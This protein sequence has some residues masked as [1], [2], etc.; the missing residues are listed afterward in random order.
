MS[1]CCY[2]VTVAKFDLKKTIESTE[3]SLKK[4]F[5]Q[6]KETITKKIDETTDSSW[7]P[8]KKIKSFF[9]FKNLILSKLPLIYVIL[10]ALLIGIATSFTPCVYP[11][12]PITIG[13]LQSQASKSLARNFLLSTSY[14]TGMATVYAV[15][16][17]FAATT[18]LIFGQWLSNPF[19][20]GLIVLLFLY[21]AFYMFGFYEIYM[22]RFLQRGSSVKVKGSFIYSF[23]FGAISGTVASPCAT[24]AIALI[25]TYVAQR[26]S[27]IIGFITFFTFAFG[28]GLLLI[29]VGT[30]SNT[31][32]NL[33]RAGTWMNEI[34]KFFGFLL[35]GMAIYFLNPVI[36]R[37]G[38]P[39][40]LITFLY[41]IFFSAMIIYYGLKVFKKVKK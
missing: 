11:M 40:F 37:F 28:M 5:S 17:Y 25:F 7:S 18:T 36:L 9:S 22:P 23:L 2:K 4:G 30:F 24:P 35:I 27:P 1:I 10:I 26:G 32:T 41:I 19:V 39:Q 29:V 8:L 6:A 33:P 12:I 15:L 21:L 14:V 34:K 3:K 13:I 38:L 16:G 20:V 31:I